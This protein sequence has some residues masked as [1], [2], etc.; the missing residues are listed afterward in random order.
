MALLSCFEC[1]G[2]VADT[3]KVCPKCGAD[4]FEYCRIS[5]DTNTKKETPQ[6]AVQRYIEEDRLKK[7]KKRNQYLGDGIGWEFDEVIKV[8]YTGLA[9]GLFSKKAFATVQIRRR[10]KQR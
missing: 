8:T 6:E 1:G 9:N 7:P 5:M 3:A 4:Q 2:P 10:K